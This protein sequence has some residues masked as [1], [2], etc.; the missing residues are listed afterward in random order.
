VL[1]G[2]SLTAAININKENLD[3]YIN[4]SGELYHAKKAEASGF[5][6]VKYIVLAIL[7]LLQCNQL[8]KS[9]TAEEAFFTENRVM[10][11]SFHRI[12][13]DFFPYTGASSEIE[14]GKA[15][16]AR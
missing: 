7:E 5:C 10:C 15:N 9:I 6:Y 11:V 3:I 8:L 2:G 14:A 1:T 4:W 12:G 13:R 16:V